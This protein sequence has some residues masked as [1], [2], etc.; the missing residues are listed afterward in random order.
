MTVYRTPEDRFADLPG[1]PYTP[2]YLEWEGLRL[3][4]ID[5]GAGPPVVLFHGEPTWSFLYRRV[6]AVLMDAGYRVIA[7]DQPGFGRSDK[8]TDPGFYTYDCH[9]AAATA[10]IEHL[11]LREATAVVQD[12]GGPIGLRIA[13]DHPDRFSRLVLLNTALF[14]GTGSPS[15]GFLAWRAFAEQAPDLPVRSIMRRTMVEQWADEVLDAYE[16][17]FPDRAAKVGAHRFPLIVP[18]S[19]EDEG[20]AEM[21]RVHAALGDWERPALV[22][23]STEDPI[24][25]TGVGRRLAERIPGAEP[26]ETVA[27]A[28][29]FLQEDRGPEVGARIA[30]FLRSSG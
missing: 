1:F 7:A 4:Y 29:H 14:T 20:A 15:P 3:H 28:G 18:L 27:G 8:P 5:E 10:V 24:F 17:P 26:F 2:N 23:F 11:D 13:V 12:W 9:T 22:L 6:A 16:A 30:G 25:S 21:Q 19:P